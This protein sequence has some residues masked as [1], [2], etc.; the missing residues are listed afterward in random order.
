MV[1]G[2]RTPCLQ[3]NFSMSNKQ[4]ELTALRV[5]TLI[6]LSFGVL[7]I[8]ISIIA[9]AN[10]M[11]LDGLYSMI[12]SLFILGSMRIVSRLFKEGDDK[13][14]PFGCG[15]FEPFFLVLRSFALLSMVFTIACI[16][17]LAMFRGG[18]TIEHGTALT[19]SAISLVVCALVWIA[20]AHLAKKLK[21][22]TL[23]SESKAWFLDTALSLA[24]VLAIA[25]IFLINQTSYAYLAVYIDPALTLLFLFC[26]SPMLIKDIVHYSRQLLGAAPSKSIQTDLEK[27]VGRFV[28]THGFRSSEVYASAR[29]RSL[30]IVI[31]IYLWREQSVSELDTIRLKMVQALH[32]Y[33]RF[34]DVDIVFTLDGRWAD[35][36][37]PLAVQNA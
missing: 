17:T 8:V 21:S 13:R 10:S 11:L 24:S 14:F 6:C 20:L 22:P 19:V 2:E 33:S 1:Q 25:S 5:T 34:C 36:Q 12:Q 27:I 7:G 37:I 23:R 32:T 30:M 15:A 28:R 31:H 3:P 29:G 26:L 4:K 16:S 9:N 18:Y 35:Y